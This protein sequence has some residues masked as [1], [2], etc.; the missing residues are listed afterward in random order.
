MAAAQRPVE[1]KPGAVPLRVW[2]A[3][4][5]GIVV[6]GSSAILVRYASSAPGLALA[7][8]RTLFAVVLL[9]PVAWFR[10]RP[11]M[12]RLGGRDLALIAG[13]GVLLGLH[14]ILYIESLYHTSV[15]SASVLVTTS[16]LFIAAL[17]YAFL[18]ERLA[19]RS[20]LAIVVAVVGGVLIG[21]ADAQAGAFPRAALGNALA[22]TA[23]L[24]FS[25]YLLVGRAV[26]QRLDF[27]AYLFPLYV[28]TA[29]TC[30]AAALVRGVSL[31]LPLPLLGLCL[32]MALGPGL[33]GH[34]SYN[35][36]V[37]YLPAALLG[38]LGL[39]EPVTASLLA[40][41]LFGERP[42]PLALAGMAVV[43]LSIAVVFARRRALRPPE[44]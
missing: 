3:L 13:A 40:F 39:T 35:Y 19:L 22:L 16:P 42:P 8:W 18:R 34:G 6:F 12:R 2:V 25:V 5:A 9:A 11:A 29:L 4:A 15:A 27:L 24:L 7:A 1:E 21:L 26:R 43:L 23:A 17:G 33:L 32:L 41:A 20:V 44:G 30:L 31:G 38:L 36:A 28:V 37:R 14:F 10:A